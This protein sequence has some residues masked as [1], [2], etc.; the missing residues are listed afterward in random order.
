[1]S[2]VIEEAPCLVPVEM[3][4]EKLLAAGELLL[5]VRERLE[6]V[7][8]LV[9]RMTNYEDKQ[10]VSLA[11]LGALTFGEKECRNAV[12]YVTD[13]LDKIAGSTYSDLVAIVREEGQMPNVPLYDEIGVRNYDDDYRGY[14]T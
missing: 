1:V 4:E 14:K 12:L 10:T 2:A 7:L 3:L 11:H 13:E 6:E 9:L 8:R 5:D